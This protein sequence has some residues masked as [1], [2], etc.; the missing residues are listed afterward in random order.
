LGKKRLI[1]LTVLALAAVG[2]AAWFMFSS[3]EPSFQGNSLNY[4]I[5]L[6]ITGGEETPSERAAA[7]AAMREKAIP[8]LCA[9]LRW[10]Q[11]A[12]VE[13]VSTRFPRL[14]PRLGYYA[15][16]SDPRWMAAYSLGELGPMARPAIPALEKLA[17]APGPPGVF[18]VDWRAR[19]TA[20]AALIQIRQEPLS[21]YIDKLK[22]PANHQ[23]TMG[24]AA[25]LETAVIVGNC[26]TNA[27][28]AVPN[29]IAALNSS[30]LAIQS[31]SLSS[32][33]WIHSRPDLCVPAVLPFLKS[34]NPVL[35][36]MAFQAIGNLGTAARP[37][38]A[39]LV[40]L[41]HDTNSTTQTYAAD[42]LKKV[43]PE[44]AAKAGVK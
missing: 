36:Q 38:A 14:L 30:D 8:Y 28:A 20:Q 21:P 44:A 15:E 6:P 12:W 29:L 24:D 23:P 18:G 39:A 42:A 34:A 16:S 19:L 27:A 40:E 32:L 3:A 7:L 13:M 22:L 4:W 35:Q 17:S 43:D 41:L 11:A 5:F 31:F 2:V 9:Q 26:G 1:A 33:A 37:A 25:W 10:K